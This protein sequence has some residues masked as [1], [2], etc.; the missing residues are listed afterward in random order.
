MNILPSIQTSRVGRPPMLEVNSGSSQVMKSIFRGVL[1]A[2]RPGTNLSFGM[3]ARS[4]HLSN[5]L[6]IHLVGTTRQRAQIEF[7]GRM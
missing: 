4:S 6:L 2:I 1:V 7:W 5:T 3:P